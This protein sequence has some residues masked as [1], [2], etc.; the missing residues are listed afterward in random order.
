MKSRNKA[1]IEQRVIDS[2]N[3]LIENNSTVRETA[4]KFG[5]SKST[6]HKDL[7]VRLKDINLNLYED[8]SVILEVNWEEKNLRGGLATKE[9]FESMK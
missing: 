9:K 5:V 8:V 4:R 6:T 3:Y 7:V 1:L 2:A